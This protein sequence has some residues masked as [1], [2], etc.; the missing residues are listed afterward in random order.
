MHK[1]CISF[2]HKYCYLNNISSVVIVN[3]RFIDL[4]NGKDKNSYFELQLLYCSKAIDS[5]CLMLLILMKLPQHDRD[6][7]QSYLV[8]MLSLSENNNP[9][10]R[11]LYYLLHIICLLFSINTI[12]AID[13]LKLLL[14][15]I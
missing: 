3:I 7:S 12:N 15:V 4:I 11:I 5:P 13:A 10:Y 1:L 14:R 6:S 9:F 2:A 8:G